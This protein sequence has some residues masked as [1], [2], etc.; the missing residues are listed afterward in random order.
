VGLARLTG[1]L[2]NAHVFMGVRVYDLLEEPEDGSPVS[3]LHQD[4]M[5]W[6]KTYLSD[7]GQVPAALGEKSFEFDIKSMRKMEEV[8][9]G[10]AL[11]VEGDGTCS[12]ACSIGSS[13]LL[14]LP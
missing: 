7:N 13:A 6:R 2:V 4:W 1:A 5:F 12:Y 10:L 9:Q 8:G 11:Y 14:V 3:G